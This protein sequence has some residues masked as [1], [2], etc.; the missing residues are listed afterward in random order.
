[1]FLQRR[2]VLCQLNH[3]RLRHPRIRNGSALSLARVCEQVIG[4]EESQVLNFAVYRFYFLKIQFP[5]APFDAENV[6]PHV[7]NDSLAIGLLL[8]SQ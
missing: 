8:V 5:V 3:T 1:M 6:V 2:Q 4:A 7:N